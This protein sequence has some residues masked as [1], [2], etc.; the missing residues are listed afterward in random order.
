MSASGNLELRSHEINARHLLRDGVLHLQ[1]GIGLDERER[2]RRA[3][4][5]HKE[6]EGA[7]AAIVAGTCQLQRRFVQVRAQGLRQARRRGDLD[8]LLMP[9][10]DAAI[11]LAQV[12][13]LGAIAEHLHLD[14]TRALHE[15]LDIERAAAE[16]RLRLRRRA[17]ERLGYLLRLLH[18]SH[19]ASATTRDSLDDRRTV[20]RNECLRL[21]CGRRARASENWHSQI[22]RE[23]ACGRLV[24]KH[25]ERCRF[26]A[27][28]DDAG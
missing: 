26:G 6:L 25:V 19:A 20:R 5:I 21:L 14:M 3:R 10:L 2:R 11:P 22:L 13:R 12:H 27:D 24:A 4:D 18:H 8:Q 15:T 17:G 28:E 1:P 9:T 16:R 23:C 7:G